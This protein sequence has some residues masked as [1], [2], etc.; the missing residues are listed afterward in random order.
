MALDF[1][2][3]CLGGFAGTVVSHP[4]DTIKVRLQGQD[5]MNPRYSGTWNCMT[6][7]IKNESV[8][9]LYKG[10]LSP[11]VCQV[12][13][14]A[15]IFGAHGNAM[16][17]LKREGTGAEMIAGSFAGGVQT[18]IS[19]PMELVKIRMQMQGLGESRTEMRSHISTAM[20]YEYANP[21]ECVKKIYK[22]E[23]GIRGLGR[24]FHI[25]LMREI[26][27]FA[28]YFGSYHYTC[29]TT[30][31]V[32]NGRI[33][34]AKLMFAGAVA[35]IV[36]WLPTYPIDVVKTR[37]QMDGMGNTLYKGAIDC[38][39]KS[40]QREGRTVFTRGLFATILRAIPMNAA[41]L[42]TVTLFLHVCQPELFDVIFSSSLAFNHDYNTLVCC[43]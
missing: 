4:L 28:L 15:I 12:G 41:T 9:G 10:L 42:T 31:A 35:G 29:V 32:E 20:R 37:L 11:L 2:A 26:P 6:T 27:S 8:Y 36:S 25:T 19:S 33:N 30:R 24:A 7:I 16:K 21:I 40:Y 14:N 3:G 5:A 18:I 43:I 38:A 1:V 34:I 13:I 22:Y 17:R 39:I 23:N